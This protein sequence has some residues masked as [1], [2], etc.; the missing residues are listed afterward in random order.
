MASWSSAVV[1]AIADKR[2]FVLKSRS[3]ILVSNHGRR[4]VSI[5]SMSSTDNP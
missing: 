2:G 5:G 1:V 3:K 4:E